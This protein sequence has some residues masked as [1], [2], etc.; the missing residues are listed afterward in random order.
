MTRFYFIPDD[1]VLSDKLRKW[2]HEKGLSDKQIEDIIEDFRDHQYKRPMMRPDAC[3]RNW[4][5]NAIKWEHVTPTTQ[6][7]YRRP[8]E[9]SEEERRREARKGEENL[10]RLMRIVK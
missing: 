7:E 9:L 3:W 1:W 8:Q 4:V 10:E 5:K 2:T 6:K